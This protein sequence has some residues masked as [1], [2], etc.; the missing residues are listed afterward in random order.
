MHF[1]CQSRV[2]LLFLWPVEE[3]IESLYL[4]NIG[5]TSMQELERKRPVFSSTEV[6]SEKK[7]F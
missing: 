4:S 7:R 3:C 1:S 2:T 5:N 6:L